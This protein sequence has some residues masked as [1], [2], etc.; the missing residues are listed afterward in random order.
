MRHWA[1][2]PADAPPPL[3]QLT[4]PPHLHQLTLDCFHSIAEPG[5]PN[6]TDAWYA[7]E[8]FID[9]WLGPV[10]SELRTQRL[11]ELLPF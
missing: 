1:W 10:A 3:H 7:A 4:P 8:P 2:K 9:T 11:R 6:P 5:T